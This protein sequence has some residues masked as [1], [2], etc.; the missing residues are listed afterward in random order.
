MPTSTKESGRER[1]LLLES[2]QAFSRGVGEAPMVIKWTNSSESGANFSGSCPEKDLADESQDQ[3][4]TFV[5]STDDV[6]RHGD[7]ISADGWV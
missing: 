7:V 3:A 5:L 6:D 1:R 4:I 2:M